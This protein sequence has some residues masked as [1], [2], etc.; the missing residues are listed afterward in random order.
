MGEPTQNSF[1][2][3]LTRLEKIHASG[4]AFE[5]T[6]TLGRS[7]FDANRQRRHRPFPWRGLA[8]VCL[9][10]LLFKAVLL[11]QLDVQLYTARVEALSN[12]SLIEQV[13]GWVL[14]PDPATHLI[15]GL[16]QPL[17]GR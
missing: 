8:L 1:K 16:F 2:E 17:F 7:Y 5:A 3:R 13:A 15:S 9:A 4:G 11:A 10:M 14:K 12:G 6:G